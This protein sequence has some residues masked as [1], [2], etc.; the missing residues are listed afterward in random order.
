[1]TDGSVFA[2]GEPNELGLKRGFC[3]GI[4]LAHGELGIGERGLNRERRLRCDASSE[5]EAAVVLGAVRHDFLHEADSVGFDGVE[6]VARENPAHR[7][8]PAR[9]TR[10][11]NGRAAERQNSSRHLDLAETR[12][13]GRDDDVTRERELNA[14][15]EARAL[16]G[17]HDGLRELLTRDLPR[18][19]A[20]VGDDAESVGADARTHVGE[21][22]TAREV[23]TVR[24]DKSD[25][26]LGVALEKAVGR[27]ELLHELHVGG[28]ALVG[29]V[30]ADEQNMPV[31]LN[32]DAG[33]V[34]AVRHATRLRLPCDAV[35]I[36]DTMRNRLAPLA[37]LAVAA[38]VLLSSCTSVYLLV[39][40]EQVAT[41]A[42]DA[43]EAQVG[44]RPE[45]DC[46]TD[47][48]KLVNNTKVDCILT[49]PAT[50][51][52]FEA[53]VTISDVDGTDYRVNVSVSDEAIKE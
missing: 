30:E 18:V 36:I 41:A 2:A 45:M 12:R 35:A 32:G 20:V 8:A 16:H 22:E 14:Q 37:V 28:V 17:H 13:V 11:P 9:R 53:P 33:G 50:G 3:S 51:E 52:K 1:M 47:D 26:K 42:E 24:E 6:H 5:L 25:A 10:E 44:S 19:D 15:G 48:V 4:P 34:T 31:A 27:R 43:L 29:S 7:V 46:G 23:I 38:G 21:V 39:S 40:P 49:D